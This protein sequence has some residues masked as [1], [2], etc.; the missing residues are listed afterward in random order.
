MAIMMWVPSWDGVLPV[1]CIVKPKPLWTG[2]QLFSLVCPKINYRG[3][4]KCKPEGGASNE[5]NLWDCDTLILNGELMQGTVDK[6]IV[7]ASS[8][9]VVHIT[10]LEKGWEETTRF[11]NECQYLVNAWMVQTS[12]TVS[13]SDTVADTQTMKKIQAALDDAK[14]KMTGIME[15]AQ[16]RNG[17]LPQQPGKSL[18]ESFE[19]AVNIVLNDVRDQCGKNA[20][21]TLKDRNAIKGTVMAGSKGSANNISQIIACVGQQ[22]VQGKRV[23]YGFSQR[24]LPHFA[25]DD[26]GMESRGFVENS[27]LRGLTPA[28]FYFHAMGG[29]EGCIDTAVKTSETGYIQ[30]RLVKAMET[31]T[32]RYDSTLRNA[33]GCIM[34]FLY[35]EDGNDA[36]R[37]EKQ[38]FDAY[39]LGLP[40]LR[41]KFMMDFN[42]IDVGGSAGSDFS[43]LD[44][45]VQEDCRLASNEMIDKMEQEFEQL[46]DDQ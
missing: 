20:S 23:Q 3:K 22:N 27:Y 44:L 28:E 14:K 15:K 7:G 4:S 31:V 43:F 30:R 35:G 42:R 45:G 29:R 5:L 25:K 36:Q 24:T 2:K 18:K 6:N 10:W 1:P 19:H 12:Y 33:S 32:A 40:K 39:K 41:A 34:Q 17:K 46:C 37:I 16:G 13:V 38:C 21:A 8:G 9:S 11:M 26:L